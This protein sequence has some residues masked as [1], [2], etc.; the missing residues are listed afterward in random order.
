MPRPDSFKKDTSFHKDVLHL[1]ITPTSLIAVTH[2]SQSGID[3]SLHELTADD[4]KLLI[5]ICQER[6]AEIEQLEK[7][8]STQNGLP[9]ENT[10]KATGNNPAPNQA[11][12][13]TSQHKTS[14]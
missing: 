7:E 1:D 13:Q 12:Q 3:I 14:A 10:E 11:I 4:V 2:Y 8:R 5:T 9:Q 6:L